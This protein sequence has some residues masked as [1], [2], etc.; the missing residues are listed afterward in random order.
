ML[1]EAF[2]EEIDAAKEAI[3]S[4]ENVVVA[5]EPFGGRRTVVDEAVTE[6]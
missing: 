6:A 1:D 4:G 5:S 3:E 2:D